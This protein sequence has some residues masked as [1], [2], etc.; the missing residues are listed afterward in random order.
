MRPMLILY[1]IAI[2]CDALSTVHFMLNEG[3]GGTEMHPAVGIAARIAG[4]VLG[5]LIGAAGKMIAGLIVA[6]YWR[7][8]AF[9]ILLIPTLMSFWAAWYNLWGWQYYEPSIF[10]WWPF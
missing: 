7:R 5:P 3:T 1:S 2:V 8:I 6:I 4:P 10:L 9:F